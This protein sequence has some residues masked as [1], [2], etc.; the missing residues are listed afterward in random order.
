MAGS[1]IFE[2]QL[3]L[4]G[5]DAEPAAPGQPMRM[6]V[7]GDFSGRVPDSPLARRPIHRIDLDNFD[8]VMARCAPALALTL[9][10]APATLRFQ[11]LDDF[12]PDQLYQQAD[13]FQPLRNQRQRLNCPATFAAAAA[14][15]QPPPVPSA[16]PAPTPSTGGGSDFASLLG[17]TVRSAAS[18]NDFDALVKVLV[19]AVPA[20]DARQSSYLAAADSVIGQRMREL[21]HA[22]AFQRLE[23]A[24]RGVHTLVT[25]LELDSGLQLHLVDIGKDELAADL[26]AAGPELRQSAL[27]QL[28]VEQPRQWPDSAPW[29]ILV[30]DYHF[31]DSEDDV[32]SLSALAALA[33]QAGAPLLAGACDS[34]LGCA[35]LAATPDP[36]DWPAPAPAAS[37]RWQ[38][39]RA[40]PHASWLG[41]ALP[42][43]L[44]R[45]PYGKQTD[46]I[47]HFNFEEADGQLDHE[48]YLWGN[49]A[50]GLAL[51][52]GQSFN[53]EGWDM[54]PGGQLELGDL[55]AHT[56]RR[57]GEARMQACAET[58]L[59]DRAAEAMLRQGLMP[60]RSLRDRNAARFQRCQSL[61]QPPKALSGR[62]QS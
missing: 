12:H 31:N 44:L 33:S 36:D 52:L 62:W 2:F 30:G 29:S 18:P 15:M 9:D 22:P 13:V 20:T 16:T 27:Y 38:A 50:F 17:G 57:D 25:G 3:A 61:A 7:L 40:S 10:G 35:Q 58:W 51:L 4:P 11:C 39:L 48:H 54:E 24:W 53:A 32:Q 49:A 14:Q 46:R 56:F 59:S 6:L 43:M 47:E 41:L 1:L 5:H 55:P 45:L 19:G 42:R 21:L 37:E 28:L 23:A 26:R 8:Q 60:L 34:V